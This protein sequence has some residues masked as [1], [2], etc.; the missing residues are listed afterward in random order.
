MRYR[1]L[2]ASGGLALVLAV[3]PQTMVTVAG[4]WAVFS[5]GRAPRIG[6]QKAHA[7]SNPRVR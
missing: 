7:Q 1:F 5:E 2:T 6:R 4:P 3:I